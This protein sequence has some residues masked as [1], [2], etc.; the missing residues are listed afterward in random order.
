L[1]KPLIYKLAFGLAAPFIG[2][3]AGLQVSPLLGN[4]LMFPFI[5]VSAL[6]DIPIGEMSGVL[7]GALV[8]LSGVAWAAL[9][10]A[11]GFILAQRRRDSAAE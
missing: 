2:L 1:S 4:I 3:F 6:T 9:L 11:P 5:A 7:F 10:S 8:L